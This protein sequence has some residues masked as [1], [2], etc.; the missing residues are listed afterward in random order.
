MQQIPAGT[1]LTTTQKKQWK[2]GPSIGSGGFGDIYCAHDTSASTPRSF[3]H[4]PL[5][6][7]I[8]PHTNGPLFVEKSFY[9]KHLLKDGLD[10]YRKR[11]KLKHLGVPHFLG[12]GS[13]EID[14]TKYRFL[15]IPRYGE[16]LQSVYLRNGKMIPVHTVYRIALQMIDVLEYIHSCQY[17][18]ADLK[19]A[20][21]TL[22]FREQASE[23]VFLVDFG[24]TARIAP[25]G[26]KPD[27]KKKHNGTIEYTSRDAHAGLTTVRG[28]LE[29]LAY[30]LIAWAG[31]SLPW[32][33][34][35]SLKDMAKV[36]AMKKDF[37]D[38][39][40]GS[41]KSCFAGKSTNF[42]PIEKYMKLVAGLGCYEVPKYSTLSKVFKDGLVKLGAPTKG[43]LEF[44]EE[45]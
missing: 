26:T 25:D 27:P 45:N 37:W 33:A 36:E 34:Q 40:T 39:L 1:L 41:L 23:H 16:S 17:V 10:D 6:V 14:G 35:R 29:I 2:V 28:D 4:Y 30:N 15:V 12:S 8:E 20:N 31:G 19:A 3:D 11:H 32:E 42:K 21:I 43:P 38:D 22:G 9:M 44:D 7:K 24:L 5:V 18:H 13:Q